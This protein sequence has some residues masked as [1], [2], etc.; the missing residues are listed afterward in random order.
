MWTDKPSW[1]CEEW[2]FSRALVGVVFRGGEVVVSHVTK[3]AEVSS[4]VVIVLYAKSCDVMCA[5][6]GTIVVNGGF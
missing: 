1:P 2:G 6:D 5:S 3:L 4:S